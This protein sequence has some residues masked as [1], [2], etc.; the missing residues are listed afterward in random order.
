MVFLKEFFENDNF[1]KNQQTTKNH[2]KF[3]GV[4][5][6]NVRGNTG[7]DKQNQCKNVNICLPV[8]FNI[9]FGCSKEPSH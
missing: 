3:P 8:S 5:S 2:D 9:C 7:L 1:E 4:Q 6:V